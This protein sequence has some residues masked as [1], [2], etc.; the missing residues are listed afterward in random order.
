MQSTPASAAS[1]KSPASTP[2]M[3]LY[4]RFMHTY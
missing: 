1:S 3:M 4:A 2:R